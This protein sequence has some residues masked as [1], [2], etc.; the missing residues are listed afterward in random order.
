MTRAKETK[1]GTED[2]T[3]SRV[4]SDAGW[5]GVVTY[6]V[7]GTVDE[8]YVEVPLAWPTT[9]WSDHYMSAYTKQLPCFSFILPV[10]PWIP[11]CALALTMTTA[12][13]VFIL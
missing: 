6:A 8:E 5:V 12:P 4:L 11:T 7:K 13:N 2:K 3:K 1:D 10:N 9:I